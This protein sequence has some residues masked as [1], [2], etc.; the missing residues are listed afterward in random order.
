[1]TFRTK[2]TPSFEE[3][4][5]YLLTSHAVVYETSDMQLVNCITFRGRAT[6]GPTWTV[7]SPGF[8]HNFGFFAGP[9]HECSNYEEKTWSVAA[10]PTQD[11][12]SSATDYVT[13]LWR[14]S[15]RQICMTCLYGGYKLVCG[16]ANC[17][18][19]YFHGDYC[20]ICSELIS[21]HAPQKKQDAF[22]ACSI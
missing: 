13:I 4:R 1:L 5:G 17:L 2:Y 14:F 11:F 9:A 20:L 16:N 15:V 6:L 7:A 22:L 3:R 10:W 8:C 18:A 21:Y 19:A 12:C